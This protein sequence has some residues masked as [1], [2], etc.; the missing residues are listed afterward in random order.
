MRQPGHRGWTDKTDGGQ[1]TIPLSNKPM[2]SFGIGLTRTSSRRLF[3]A[4]MD[5][6]VSSLLCYYSN[7]IITMTF[8][9]ASLQQLKPT[10]SVV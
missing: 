2:I 1:W 5:I 7:V 4:E 9:N 10:H 3:S 6:F 8:K